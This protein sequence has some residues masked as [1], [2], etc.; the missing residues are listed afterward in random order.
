M[1]WNLQNASY[2][3]ALESTRR[4]SKA[5]RECSVDSTKCNFLGVQQALLAVLHDL[6]ITISIAV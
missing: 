3:A 5:P 6:Y 2:N 4:P 1:K